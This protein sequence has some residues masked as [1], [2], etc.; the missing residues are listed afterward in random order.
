M[1]LLAVQ[2]LSK[3]RV[4]MNNKTFALILMQNNV[5]GINS[6]EIQE[7]TGKINMVE[8]FQFIFFLI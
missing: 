8:I 1:Q 7:I 4:Y 6:F 5:I 3:S 2:A